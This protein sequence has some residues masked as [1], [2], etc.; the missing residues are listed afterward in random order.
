MP[1]PDFLDGS[2]V[3]DLHGTLVGPL[4]VEFFRSD[5]QLRVVWRA[6]IRGQLVILEGEVSEADGKIGVSLALPGLHQTPLPSPEKA[7]PNDAPEPARDDAPEAER[8]FA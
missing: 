7:V 8:P 5:Y 2:W 3:G 1:V 4:F 6:N